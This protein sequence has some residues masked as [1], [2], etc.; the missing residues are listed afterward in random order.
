MYNSRMSSLQP[1]WIGGFKKEGREVTGFDTLKQ[2]LG[3]H[4]DLVEE[5]NEPFV[6][7]ETIREHQWTVAH[8]T[9]WKR[10]Q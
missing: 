6:I 2:V 10:N 4:F 5:R 3:Q 8:V 1:K 7:R 9:V